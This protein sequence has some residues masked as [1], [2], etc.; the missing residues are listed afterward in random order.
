MR[1]S[2]CGLTVF[3]VFLSFFSSGLSAQVYHTVLV[4]KTAGE[5]TAVDKS[6]CTNDAGQIA[7]FGSFIGFSNDRSGDTIFLCLGDSI[8]VN[9]DENSVDFS[10]DPVPNTPAGIGYVPFSCPPTIDGP[11]LTDI[12]SDNCLLT[13]TTFPPGGDQPLHIFPGTMGLA[14]SSWFWND[15]TTQAFF[16]TTG[17]PDPLVIFQ[18]PVTF[19]ALVNG[20]PSYEEEPG[21][22]EN[23]P[24][25]NLATDQTF[26]IAYLNAIEIM[27]ATTA[28]CGGNFRIMGGAPQLIGGDYNISISLAGDPSVVA[29]DIT[30]TDDVNGGVNVA[31]EIPQPGDYLVEVT[32][33]KA[34]PASQVISLNGCDAVSFSFPFENRAPGESFCVPVTV[35]GF[36]DVTAFQYTINYDPAVLTYT[37]ANTPNASI[38]G[39]T[40]GAF[41]GPPSSGGNQAPGVIRA[42]YADLSGNAVTLNDGEVVYEL[43]FTVN[44]P[45]GNCSP[46][47]FTDDPLPIRVTVE[48][49]SGTEESGYTLNDGGVCIST[50]AYFVGV[51]QDSL[52]C[53]GAADGCLNITLS[54]GVAPY[55]VRYRRLDPIPTGFF[56]PE[57]LTT[58]NAM[59]RY[60]GLV[61]GRYIV[62][63]TDDTG[64]EIL[65]TVRVEA[66]TTPNLTLDIT[67]V[68]CNSLQDGAA[69]AII[70]LNG[71]RIMDPVAEGYRFSWNVSSANSERLDGLSGGA[72]QVVVTSP[73]GCVYDL[74][75]GTVGDPDPLSVAPMAND[76]ATTDATCTGSLNGSITVSGVGGTPGANG[77]LFE[78]SNGF[79][80]E[81]ANSITVDNLD[82]GT[83]TVTITDGNGCMAT[84]DYTV[85]PSKVL[86]VNAVVEDISC[87]G[88]GNGSIF[89]TGVTTAV[90]DPNNTPATPYTFAWGANAPTPTET[91]TTTQIENL[92][93]GVYTLSMTD[94]DGCSVDTM[95][96]VVEPEPLV[97]DD[98][99]TIGESCNVGMDGSAT[100]V[101][102][103]GTEPYSYDWS[104]S[105]TETDSI[106]ENLSAM[107]GYTVRVTDA[108][109]CTDD[110]TFDILAPTPPQITQ[111]EDDFVSCPDATDGSLTVLATPSGAP[112][113][114]YEWADDS[115]NSLGL[116]PNTTTISNLSPGTYFVT[117]T[118]DNACFV[119]DSA[120]VASPGFVV[121]DSLQVFTPTCVG[122]SDG[123]IRLFPSGGTAP[124]TFT[125]STNPNEPGTL[126]PLTGLSAGTYSFTVTDANGCTPLVQEVTVEDPPAVVANFM[127]I[128]GVSCPDDATCD[129]RATIE[130]GFSDGSS[131]AFIFSW[132]DG[133]TDNAG[134]SISTVDQLCRGAFSVSIT[135]GS[136]G[137]VFSDTI[138]SPEDIVI[139]A[140]IERVTCFGESDGSV[141]LSPS[142]GTGAF[143]FQWMETGGTGA[144][145]SN[146]SAGLYTAIV[147][148]ANGCARTQEVEI[149]EP[150]PLVLDVDPANSTP[151]VSCA[152][153]MDATFGVFVSSANN[154][155]LLPEPF[156][157]SGGIAGPTETLA[158]GLAPG[159]Y[160]VTVTDVQGC[161]DD[162][163]FTIGEPDAI[164]FSVLPIEEPLC[165]GET[166]LVL[167]DTAFGG[168]ASNFDDFTFSVNNDGF[169]IPVTQP[170]STFAGQT[171]VSVFDTVG[172]SAS[173]TFNINQPPPIL[174]DLP[175]SI[176]IE[177]GDSLTVLNPIISPAGDIYNYQWTPG[178]FLNNDTIRN[179][180]IFP[181]DSREYTLAVTNAN[182]CQAFADIFVDVDANRNVYIPNV[183]SPNRDGRNEDFRIYAC[184]GVSSVN[185][186]NIFDRWG[187]LIF[188]Q[189]NIMPNCLD[190][191]RLWD[192]IYRGKTVDPGVFIYT[193]EVTFLDGVTLTYR[194]DVVVLR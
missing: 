45:L 53:P 192:G 47:A 165:F 93:A 125:W 3:I 54:G 4:P 98:V 191:I 60:C 39:L 25:V 135:D 5:R 74:L 132:S 1:N 107:I 11:T 190:G 140:D 158:T 172:C 29:T 65:D 141:T 64:E 184:Q 24:C 77:Y 109:G 148:D 62:E 91:G 123:R 111:F 92:S 162:A 82:P 42:A 164:I 35:E 22:N 186:V 52:S 168:S 79:T 34:C 175:E 139:G 83:Y 99:I 136:C 105:T 101:I 103:G 142:G 27:D 23:G 59:T 43:C 138:R 31:F 150:D 48:G 110:A 185:A 36:I 67:P 154:N 75:A 131:G 145:E 182:G 14:G 97:I 71:V 49:A 55:D 156:A 9:Y 153:D 20:L 120:V 147:T 68:S 183:F 96:T 122:D 6:N 114:Q 108:N 12:V 41:N 10:G 76:L 100:L 50:D 86:S 149:T 137:A 72:I 124:Y 176:T 116:G 46:L 174:V 21:S 63:V 80:V 16:T 118:D 119:V 112:I 127:D 2:F 70:T 159:T 19:D 133:T 151:T 33:E 178:D 28:G 26:A 87:N 113:V 173:D 102:S 66:P 8:F 155:P 90:G 170:G 146:L 193:I 89:A 95:F 38:P 143:S 61:A 129:G 7:N 163:S 73:E 194:G 57:Q 126:N 56:G 81:S 69:E 15:G 128:S 117:I 144:V 187:G 130:A 40:P 115:G 180:T 84:E 160:S 157:W 88:D 94:Q 78:W 177:L 121:L 167:I 104:H 30:V 152:G 189:D 134:L 179:P 166:T 17:F 13:S 169:R 44:A 32:D 51:T 37:G 188:T 85:V 161:M 171:V 181:F 106:A 18:T 58:T